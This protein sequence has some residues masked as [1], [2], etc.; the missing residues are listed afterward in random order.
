MDKKRAPSKELLKSMKD[1]RD[2]EEAEHATDEDI[3]K[4]ALEVALVSD[5]YFGDVK[6]QIINVLRAFEKL[7]LNEK[8]ESLHEIINKK[9]S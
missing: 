8:I 9:G 4:A 3:N 6:R 2:Y 5:S 1:L 7:T